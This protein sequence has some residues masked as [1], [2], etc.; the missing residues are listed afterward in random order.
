MAMLD[1]IADGL[2]RECVA[3]QAEGQDFEQ[4]Y[5]ALLRTH[6]LAGGGKVMTAHGES[7]VRSIPLRGGEFVLLYDENARRWSLQQI[8][9]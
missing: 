2:L 1:S 6:E 9:I 8:A 7:T 5:R 3:R 4:I